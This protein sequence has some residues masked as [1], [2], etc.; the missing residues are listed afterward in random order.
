M[1]L[2]IPIRLS[3]LSNSIQSPKRNRMVLLLLPPFFL[4]WLP[5]E[6]RLMWLYHLSVF[7]QWCSTANKFDRRIKISKR[8]KLLKCLMRI[9]SNMQFVAMLGKALYLVVPLLCSSKQILAGW[10]ATSKCATLPDA[11]LTREG[12]GSGEVM[13][14][15]RGNGKRELTI[16]GRGAGNRRQKEMYW[17]QCIE[18]TS[19]KRQVRVIVVAVAM[20][21][22]KRHNLDL[23]K[24]DFISSAT[25]GCAYSPWILSW[26]FHSECVSMSEL[27]P[28]ACHWKHLLPSMWWDQAEQPGWP[29]KRVQVTKQQLLVPVTTAVLLRDFNVSLEK[30]ISKKRL[31]LVKLLGTLPMEKRG[32]EQEKLGSNSLVVTKLNSPLCVNTGQYLYRAV[33]K[34]T[35][36]CTVF[37]TTLYLLRSKIKA[38]Q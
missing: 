24:P 5:S 18:K 37:T 33:P 34:L 16:L 19:A 26:I 27:R 2:L 36:C 14:K 9:N 25:A 31:F 6:R 28:V 35:S 10:S 22:C 38:P 12:S 1:T 3:D 13:E 29:Q 8:L 7:S 4:I 21:S 32:K 15:V 11:Q 23:K 30:M 20:G 17:E